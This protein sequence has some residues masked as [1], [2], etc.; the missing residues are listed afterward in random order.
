MYFNS[1]T[2]AIFLPIVFCLYWFVFGR[3]LKWQNL[4]VLVASYV[5]YGWWDWR[6]LLLIALTSFCSFWSGILIDKY[7]DDKKKANLINAANIILN[8]GILGLF[9][10]YN[11]FAASFANLFLGGHSDKLLMHLI[12]PVGI[13]FYTFQALSYTIDVHRGKIEPTRDIVRFFA[14]VSFFPQL[15]AGPIERASNLLPQFARKRVF[16]PAQAT[17]GLRL[18]LWGLFKKVVVADQCARYVDQVF[19]QQAS[20]PGGTL[21]LGVVLF[22]FQIYGDFSGYSDIAIGTSKLFGIKLMTNFRTPYF[23]RNIKEFWQRW[24]ISLTTWLR[25]YVYFP[26]GGSRCSKAKAIRNN[27]IVFILCGLWHGASWTYIAWG[28]YFGTL[29]GISILYGKGHNYK[30]TVAQ[31]KLFPSL[32]E[33]GLI[34]WMNILNCLGSVFFRSGNIGDAWRYFLGFFNWKGQFSGSGV[35]TPSQMTAIFA[36]SLVMFGIEWLNREK[37]HGLVM[38]G[39]KSRPLRWAIYLVLMISVLL[40]FDDGTSPFVYF[41]F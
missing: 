6:F 2:Y 16:D 37:E 28:V 35:M 24:H 26:L 18:I 14:Y 21:I 13:S 29:A 20:L 15:V 33:V 4:F 31:G 19:S 36:G 27:Y 1:L 32:K 39:V 40:F 23:S 11:F 9:K 41:Q 38:D 7:R 17:D 12:L 3:N 10:Y 34:L 30:D 8:L 22:T 5:F 25:D